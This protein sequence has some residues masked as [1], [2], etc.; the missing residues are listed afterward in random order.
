MSA[1]KWP[2]YTMEVGEWRQMSWV[3]RSFY[4]TVSRYGQETGKKFRCGRWDKKD[5][6][7]PVVV[8]R[9]E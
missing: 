2:I 5:P 3:P 8:R 9:V 6:R 7:S 1:K 4:A